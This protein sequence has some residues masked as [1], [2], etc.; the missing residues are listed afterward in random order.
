MSFRLSRSHCTT[1]PPIKMLPSS[2]YSS[3]R[4]R[5]QVRVVISRCLREQ[6]SVADV[7]QQE[8]ARAIG[9]F[10]IAGI[11]AELAEECGLL[12]SG[13]AGDLDGTQPERRRHFADLLAGPDDLRHHAVGNAEELEQLLVPLAFDD[14]E[15]HGARGVG[16]VGHMAL[17]RWS[18]SR[19]ASF[20]GAEGE[21]AGLGLLRARRGHCP[22]SRR[23]WLPEK[24]GSISRPVFSADHRLRAILR[25]RSHA[26]RGAAVLPD[27]RVVD[28]LARL[29]V[30]HNRGFALVG[31]AERRH[32]ARA[33]RCGFAQHLNGRTELRGKNVEGIVLYPAGLGINLRKFMLS[34]GENVAVSGQREWPA[35]WWFPGR[36]QGC[37]P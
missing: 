10:G 5:L 17:R 12:V 16:V 13:D 25:S 18:G 22:E 3:L 21:L 2:A 9:V 33:S 20:D 36:A 29:A 14:V 19:S 1:A 24:Y 4:L 6:K 31:D 32:I 11:E 28:G 27:N 37:M 15:E 23:S 30:P 35:N 8:T 7:L 34:L 26:R